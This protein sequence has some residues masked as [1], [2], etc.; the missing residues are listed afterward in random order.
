MERVKRQASW[1][2][3]YCAFH[4]SGDL[5]S[6][7]QLAQGTVAAT[8]R[9]LESPARLENTFTC[10]SNNHDNTHCEVYIDFHHT[11]SVA[12]TVQSS[13]TGVEASGILGT[14]TPQTSPTNNYSENSPFQTCKHTTAHDTEMSDREQE[15]LQQLEQQKVAS[16]QLERQMTEMKIQNQIELEV[17]KQQ[18][19]KIAMNQMKEAQEEAMK[20]Q[21]SDLKSIQE[22]LQQSTTQG[23]TDLFNRIKELLPPTETEEQKVKRLQEEQARKENKERVE[24]LV[25]QQKQLQQQAS[26]LMDS[27]MDEETRVL[28]RTLMETP[29]QPTNSQPNQQQLQQQLLIDQLRKAL[30]T[31]ETEDPQKTILKQFLT[32]SNTIPTQGGTNDPQATT[33]QTAHGGRGRLQHG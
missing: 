12:R 14:A 25:Q 33:T 9:R 13:V 8:I 31:K 18:Q 24:Q 21:A 4:N 26:L 5:P 11:N 1:V 15:L 30:G 28:L 22:I 3:D 19:W 32:K 20:K 27:E 2:Q 7:C 29:S 6:E 17:Q 16:L 23:D 10:I